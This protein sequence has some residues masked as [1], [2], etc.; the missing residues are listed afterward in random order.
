MD[1]AAFFAQVGGMAAADLAAR[2]RAAAIQQQWLDTAWY[3]RQHTFEQLATDTAEI[4]GLLAGHNEQIEAVRQASADMVR[5]NDD[6]QPSVDDMRSYVDACTAQLAE[7]GIAPAG[8]FA[9]VEEE[10]PAVTDDE[11]GSASA[12]WSSGLLLGER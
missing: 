9:A 4:F 2:G 10:V 12:N 1:A 11:E 3:S 5:G 8:R 7:A 6:G